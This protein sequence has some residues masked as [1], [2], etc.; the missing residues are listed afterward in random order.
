[1]PDAPVI[2]N[3]FFYSGDAFGS[4]DGA[5]EEV[6]CY[7][8]D[9]H[10]SSIF[11]AQSADE[12]GIEGIP[13]IGEGRGGEGM[14][15]RADIEETRFV[16]EVCWCLDGEGDTVNAVFASWSVWG[17]GCWDGVNWALS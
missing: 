8:V 12:G 1:M 6:D 4:T 13:S 9:P 11:H 3:G 17:T 2:G 15:Y 5:A 16:V 7:R 14:G 10:V